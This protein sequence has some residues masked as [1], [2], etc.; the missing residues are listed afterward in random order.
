MMTLAALPRCHILMKKPA[1]YFILN[2]AASDLMYCVLAMPV[3]AYTYLS[4]TDW[5]WSRTAKALCEWSAWIKYISAFMDWSSLAL[6]AV[7]R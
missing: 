5:Q 6:I 2:L 4:G 7:E 3:D 1:T